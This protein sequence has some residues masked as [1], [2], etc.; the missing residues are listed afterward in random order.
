MKHNPLISSHSS[1]LPSHPRWQLHCSLYSYGH[2]LCRAAG[3]HSGRLPTS[4]QL[5]HVHRWHR[6][7]TLRSV[8]RVHIH[9]QGDG[10]QEGGEQRGTAEAATVR[11][12]GHADGWRVGGYGSKLCSDGWGWMSLFSRE[13]KVDPVQYMRRCSSVIAYIWWR[14]RIK[15]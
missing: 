11:W 4:G 2:P 5:L 3:L 1:V 9:R 15:R 7:A 14:L 6:P 13:G 8:A 10:E 12:L